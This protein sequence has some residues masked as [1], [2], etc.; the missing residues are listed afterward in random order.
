MYIMHSLGHTWLFMLGWSVLPL[1]RSKKH[2]GVYV[3]ICNFIDMQIPFYSF[4]F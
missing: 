2:K 1:Y 4:F 3:S